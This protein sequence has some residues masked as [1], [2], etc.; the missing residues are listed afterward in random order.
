[1]LSADSQEVVVEESGLKFRVDL[2]RYLDPG[3]FLDHRLTRAMIRADAAEKRV[4][5]LFSYTGSFSVYA[6]AGGATST[7]SVDLSSTYLDWSKRNFAINGLDLRR[8]EFVRADAR[9]WAVQSAKSRASFDLIILD[10]PSFSS[11]KAMRGT[12]DVQR[13]HLRIIDSAAR[14]LSSAGT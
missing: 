12:F 14:L 10:P 11:S 5:N 3:L 2:T 6:A 4:L 13:D 9:E 8:H 7:T 1:K